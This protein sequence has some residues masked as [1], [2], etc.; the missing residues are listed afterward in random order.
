MSLVP[1]YA[2]R[3]AS[4]IDVTKSLDFADMCKQ[5]HVLYQFP[6]AIKNDGLSHKLEK[7][8]KDLMMNPRH[9]HFQDTPEA[10][11]QA[12]VNEF[13]ANKNMPCKPH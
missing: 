10:L 5:R 2:G 1:C 8:S 6:E 12:L 7:G 13:V 4:P 3:T 9:P 11:D